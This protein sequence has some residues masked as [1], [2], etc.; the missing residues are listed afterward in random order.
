MKK[1]L[2]VSVLF[3]IGGFFFLRGQELPGEA[4]RYYDKGCEILESAKIPKDYEDAI[5]EFNNAIALDP[6]FP[7]SYNKLGE[8]YEK[9][10]KYQEAIENFNKCL[11]F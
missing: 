11:S 6:N 7:E 2:T 8:V 1:I 9:L 4:K 5:K 3:I 10:E